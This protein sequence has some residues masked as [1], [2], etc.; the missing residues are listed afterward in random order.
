MLLRSHDVAVEYLRRAGELNPSNQ[1]NAADMGFVLTFCG[2]PEA[3]LAS[4]KRAREIDKYFDPPWYW[5]SMGLAYTIL[6]RYEEA[7]AAFE[8]LPIRKYWV[9]AL[10][11]ACHHRL[12]NENRAAAFVAECLAARPDF[13]INRRMRREPFKNSADVA[14]L[15]ESLRMAGLPE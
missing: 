13:S 6:H 2:E 12:G 7:L 4:F 8:H 15:T 14:H 10:M 5:S 11:A 1:W 9:S 3:A